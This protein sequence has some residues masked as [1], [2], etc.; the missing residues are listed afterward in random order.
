MLVPST[1]KSAQGALERPAHGAFI[2]GTAQELPRHWLVFRSL[3]ATATRTPHGR[4]E[5]GSNR[6]REPTAR[7]P[8]GLLPRRLARFH[9]SGPR[10]S[11][12]LAFF[13]TSPSRCLPSDK[14][15]PSFQ[16]LPASGFRL[17]HPRLRPGSWESSSPSSYQYV[18]GPPGAFSVPFISSP[19]IPILR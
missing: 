4:G 11:V 14:H 7:P 8:C 10:P 13:V 6:R 18:S 5:A 9:R 12:L 19:F 1:T 2:G 17:S 16:P 15:A 3:G